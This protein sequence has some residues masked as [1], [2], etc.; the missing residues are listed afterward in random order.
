[1]KYSLITLLLIFTCNTI[2]AQKSKQIDELLTTYEKA[3]QFSGS[4]LV[5]KKGKI[6]FEK[7]YGYRNAPKREK[8]TN[9]SRYRIFSTTKIFTATVILKLEEQGKLSLDDKLSKYF[10]SF[11]KGDSITIKNML[12][13]TSGIPEVGETGTEVDLLKQLAEKPLDFSPNTK[14]SYSN[15]N[16]YLLGYLIKKVT[17]IEYDKAIE[18]F[19]L[20]PLQMTNSGFHFNDLK[21]EN[22]TF[23]YE[24]MSGENSNEALRFKTDQP[25]AAGA[26]YSTVEDLYKFSEAFYKGKILNKDVVK[27]MYTPYLND[28]YGFAQDVYKIP[29]SSKIMVGHSGVGPGYRCIFNRD[30]DQDIAIIVL[31]NTEMT[32]VDKITEDITNIVYNMPYTKTEIGKV[33]KTDLQKMEGIYSSSEA[34]YYVNI[35]DGMVVINGN[36][37]Q[38]LPL[39]PVTKTIFKLDY[40]FA[41]N[42]T[43]DPTGEVKSIT[44]NNLISKE[45]KK[46][47]K[48]ADTFPW[49]IIG[50]ATPSG[51]DGKDIVLQTEKSNPNYYFLKNYKLK[52]GELRFRLNNDWGSSLAL[53]NDDKNLCYDGYNIKITEDGFYDIVLDM[54]TKSKPK[55][56][57]QLSDN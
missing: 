57:I 15:T 48:I 24:F 47:K 22:K 43:T 8:N 31:V 45:I 9:N 54:T 53:N 13:H 34:T 56:S 18:E 51:W 26:M 33:N 25:F 39:I 49:G 6:I 20:K 50:T 46:A 21:N 35:I 23:G 14:W 7:S 17:G 2:F 10:P 19:I 30:L 29:N 52:V 5:A 16:Y 3:N 36:I 27:T 44:V 42:F 12:S 28:H 4:V 41:F 55:Y 1:M 38:R 11:P 40:N 32:P 37:F